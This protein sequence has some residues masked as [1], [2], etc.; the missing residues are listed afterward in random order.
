MK[1][2]SELLYWREFRDLIYYDKKTNTYSYDPKLPERARKS[3]ENW[4]KQLDK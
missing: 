2:Y 1:R 4:L 3:H